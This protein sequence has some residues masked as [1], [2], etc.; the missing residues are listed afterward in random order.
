MK[1]LSI[2]IVLLAALLAGMGVSAQ[3]AGTPY[4]VVVDG[5]LW[6]YA[7]GAEP[8]LVMAGSSQGFFG[9]LAW[10]ADGTKLAFINYDYSASSMLVQIMVYDMTTGAA[11]FGL[12]TGFLES[13][14]P[15]SFTADGQILFAVQP[16]TMP[17]GEQMYQT[18]IYTVAP[19]AA[20]TPALVAAL[21]YTVGCGGGSP[22]P[23]DNNYW[24]ETGF[25]GNYLLLQWT[26]A[27]IVY[28]TSCSGLGSALFDPQTG[29]SVELGTSLA[30][31]VISP[32]G[33]RLAGISVSYGDTGMSGA[34]QIIDLAT[35]QLTEV[36]T[37][38][39]PDQLAWSD[40]ETLLYSA[41]VQSGNLLEAYSAE[42]QAVL[43]ATFGYEMGVIPVYSVSINTINLTTGS[44]SSVYVG[45]AWA[46]GRMFRLADG[47]ILFSA[48]PNLNAW[49]A[50]IADGS[51]DMASEESL[52]AGSALVATQV[53][54]L[55]NASA[56]NWGSNWAQITPY[57]G[58]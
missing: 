48:V 1:G 31:G 16:P 18:E 47:R 55:E 29:E 46:I 36:A 39:I 41:R 9:S 40:N 50:G 51:I 5:N 38:V 21:D 57:L 44:E 23:T 12:N 26:A 22:Y 25:G 2:I 54:V 53:F 6:V 10:N 24:R 28:S 8:Q 20:A 3:D 17:D 15:I 32:D 43:N 7:P 58:G 33:T 4:A 35:R 42:Q 11:P 34:L 30:R 56:Q 52:E 14:F 19:D 27:G 37:M 45:A 13:G 49:V